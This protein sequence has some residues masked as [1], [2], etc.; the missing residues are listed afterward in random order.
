MRW[1]RNLAVATLAVTATGLVGGAGAVTAAQMPWRTSVTAAA[2]LAELS[3]EA[4]PWRTTLMGLAWEAKPW[5]STVVEL[6]WRAKPWRAT[7]M[8]W[9]T[10]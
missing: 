8:P 10:I 1:K 6:S 5:R 2:E 7:F 4:K 9:R 3:W